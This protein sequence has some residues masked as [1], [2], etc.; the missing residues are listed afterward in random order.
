MRAR[1]LKAIVVLLLASPLLHAE[2]LS[3]AEAVKIA[4]GANPDVLKGR[5]QL[6]Y[7]DGRITEE[8]SAALP[9]LAMRGTMYRYSDPSLLNSANFD[10]LPPEFGLSLQPVA[11]NI[12]E[13]S[14]ELRQ[15]LYSF[16]VGQAIQA[17]RIARQLGGADLR[18]IQQEI[19]LQTVKAYNALLFAGEQVRVQQNAL[20]QKEKHL[21]LTRNRRKAGVATE[22]DVLRAEVSVENQRAE[23]TRAEGGVELA[24]AQL[25]ALML[26]P[27][28]SPISP[29]D[30]LEFVPAEFVPE[31]VVRQAL[32]NRPDLAVAE[33]SLDVRERVVGISKAENKPSLD[34]VGSY[35]RSTR[36][37]TNFLDPDFGKWTAAINVRIPIFDGRRTAGKVAQAQAEASKARQ[38][39]VALQ[40]AIRLEAVDALVK[41]NVATRLIRAAQ[42]NVEQ[43]RKAL[44]MTQAN[45]NYGA[46]TVLDV[47]DAENA[48]LAAE[49]TLVQALQEHADARA[50]VNY[51]MGLDPSKPYEEAK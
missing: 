39:K 24:R 38:D 32:S 11:S 29:S 3:R 8:K 35:G 10:Q 27:M 2:V 51:V 28:D 17:A 36:K 47:T 15:T 30:N 6:Q 12:Y 43:A 34:F 42:L 31:D 18:R 46:A 45:Y 9:D 20:A 49:T 33:L 14:F 21:E 23:M 26:R 37:P 25:N 50:S 22:L 5:A 41:L 16:K 13:G 1:I 48:L 19:A 7:L 4:L 44:T 40:N